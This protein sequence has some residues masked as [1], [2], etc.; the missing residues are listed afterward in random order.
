M[1]RKYNSLMLRG[2]NWEKWSDLLTGVE[3][4]G[5]RAE[6]KCVFTVSYTI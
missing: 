5:G 2:A 6:E 4:V 3:M 1:G